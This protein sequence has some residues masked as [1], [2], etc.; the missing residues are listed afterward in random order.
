[1]KG[2]VRDIELR[3]LSALMIN[4]RMSDR[5]LAKK[6]GVSQ[7]TVSRIR[8][9]L[10][11]EGYIKEYAAIPD[12]AK[13]GYEIFALTFVKIKSVSD[14][15][16][17]LAKRVAEESLVKGP[18]N[19]VMF[20]RGSGLAYEG[21]LASYHEDYSSYMELVR[22]LRQIEFLEIDRIDSYIVSLKDPVRYRPLTYKTL[23]KHI[24][25]RKKPA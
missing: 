17:G 8:M 21:M 5:A 24:L 11:K 15:K 16:I 22:Y 25:T 4:G 12:L 20:E 6:L 23:A 2:R 18:H 7:P 3:V 13:L 14:E 19:V 1:V 10:E 9:K